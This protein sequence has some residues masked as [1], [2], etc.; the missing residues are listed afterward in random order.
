MLRRQRD[1]I[2]ELLSLLFAVGLLSHTFGF[3][4][5]YYTSFRDAIRRQ[6]YM[7]SER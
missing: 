6:R 4:P 5:C 2:Q 7:M 3:P 1:A